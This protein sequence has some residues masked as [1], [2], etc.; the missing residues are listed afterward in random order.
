MRTARQSAAPRFEGTLPGLGSRRVAP[1]YTYKARVKAVPLDGRAPPVWGFTLDLSHR[2]VL[3]HAEGMP[4]VDSL[5]VLKIYTELGSLKLTARVVHNVEGI[6]FGCEF[7]D[8]NDPLRRELC[9]LVALC[10]AAPEP[11][12]TIH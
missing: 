3:V 6:G 11:M 1:R 5:V 2:G 4:A 12:R 9:Q 8:L 7:I 10:A